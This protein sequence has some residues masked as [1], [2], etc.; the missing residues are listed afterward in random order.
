MRAVS[1]CAFFVVVFLFAGELFA[2]D[3][4]VDGKLKIAF[5]NGEGE[6]SVIRLYLKSRQLIIGAEAVTFSEDGRVKLDKF[7]MAQFTDGDSLPTTIR[8]DNVILR[9]DS[10]IKSFVDIVN[11]KIQWIELS[12]GIRLQWEK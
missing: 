3:D 9:L 12:G 4:I 8:A 11:R 10:P 2:Q 6:K 1:R 5:P 7:L